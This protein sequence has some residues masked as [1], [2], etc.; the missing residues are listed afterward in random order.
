MKI[1]KKL[2][3]AVWAMAPLLL[4][5]AC[6]SQKEATQTTAQKEQAEPL[7]S[8]E[9]KKFSAL[10]L[11][12]NRAKIIGNKEEAIELYQKCLEIDPSSGA[13]NYDLAR[14][15]ADKGN[16]ST[17]LGYAE[18][19]LEAEPANEWFANFL[20]QLYAEVGRIG[21]SIQTYRDI[22]EKQP[23]NYEHYFRLSNLLSAQG[24]YD[25]ALNTLN[26]LEEKV[27]E[28]E[29]LVMQRQMLYIEQGNYDRAM[30]EVDELIKES[31][32]EIRLYGMKAEILQQQGEEEKARLLYKK[33]LEM[34]PDNGLVLL[35]LYE[36]AKKNDKK[37][38]ADEYLNRAFA[39]LE[40]GIDVKINILL[41]ILSSPNLEENRSQ[42]ISLSDQLI[43]AHPDE[44]KAYA[45]SGDIY[46]NLDD[47]KQ[48]RENF[49]KAVELDPN[50]PPLW[51][52]ILTINSQLN[53][54][55]AMSRE[56]DEA[57][58][59]YPQQPAFYLFKGIANIQN[60]N[61][62]QAIDALRAGK[63]LVVDD[64]RTLAQF[65]ASLGDAYHSIGDHENSDKSYDMA[66]KYNPQNVIVLNNYAYYLSQREQN[67]E[68]AEEMSK[69]ANDLNPDEA[70]F[71]DTYAWV[72]YKRENFRNAL[73]WIE[74]ALKNG[75]ARDAEVLEHY[76][77]ILKALGR[78]KEAAEQ[79]EKAI[80]VGGNAIELNTKIEA[81]K[82]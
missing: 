56:S 30:K 75:A 16:Y 76:G 21:E 37:Y 68:K 24:K 10:F 70:S 43:K 17:A 52:Q 18:K 29:K 65:Y 32:E 50:R 82:R 64:Q 59:L 47:L 9:E 22:I 48:A 62:E 38:K 27:G 66:L 67:L 57:L 15:M 36:I 58:E 5:S 49:R 2:H 33:M 78:D 79:W 6:S 4:I 40:L 80:S 54:F 55:D 60:N 44:A 8:S 81:L 71:Q 35:S 46:Y 1:F 69:K 39:T 74:E 53:D 3:I 77:H 25:E 19:A 31:P 7:S 28:S 51:E 14:L 63:N 72:L 20:G 12:A 26:T 23:L 34:E 13:A 45:I 42:L 41:N 73:F 11:D 61:P